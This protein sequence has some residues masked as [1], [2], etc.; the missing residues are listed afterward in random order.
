MQDLPNIKLNLYFVI[1]IRNI[2]VCNKSNF[3]FTSS[4]AIVLFMTLKFFHSISCS[5]KN[6]R[7]SSLSTFID[8]YCSSKAHTPRSFTLSLYQAIILCF[9][10]IVQKNSGALK[11]SHIIINLLMFIGLIYFLIYQEV[12]LV[13]IS[14][15]FILS[16]VALDRVVFSY[17]Y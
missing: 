14:M 12:I 11:K 6:F 9:C 17:A 13:N 16:M 1:L 10:N 4:F 3:L 2:I 5:H 15:L 8:I 7:E